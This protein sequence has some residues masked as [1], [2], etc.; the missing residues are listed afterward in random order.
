MISKKTRKKKHKRNIPLTIYIILL[1]AATVMVSIWGGAFSYVIFY[2]FLS[3]IPL[4]L[5]YMV[6]SMLF[7]NIYQET[8][9]RMINKNVSDK[10]NLIIE[11]T[12]IFPIGGIKFL[13]DKEI[14]SFKVDFTK[15]SFSL[16]FMEKQE[17][18]T[19]MT[20]LLAGSIDAGVKEYQL[21]DMF[22]IMKIRRKVKIPIRVHVLPL[23]RKLTGDDIRLIN[24]WKEK[25]NRFSINMPEDNLGNDLRKYAPGDSLN[26]VHWK[27]YARTGQMFVRLPEKQEID[28]L[29]I[30]LD[31]DI[32]DG[33]LEK[34]RQR[35]KYLEYLASIGEY[36]GMMNKPLVIYYYNV[37]V[38]YYLIDSPASFRVFY[39]EM[40]ENIGHKNAAG[41]TADL[42]AEANSRYGSTILFK[43]EGCELTKEYGY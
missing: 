32:M 22:G 36:F 6:Y 37:G 14:N 26:S 21:Q 28:M 23:I 43:E 40:T 11:N 18:N 29:C 9:H 13:Y 3:Y 27:N 8:E 25:G 10:Y 35:D 31:T 30:A 17:I 1:I 5:L 4:S 7:L 34:L 19:E 41:H 24:E 38:K 20:C 33:T 42:I 2:V 15:D 16:S 12:G 39:T